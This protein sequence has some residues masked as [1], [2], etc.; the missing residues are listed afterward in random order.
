MIRTPASSIFEPKNPR[1]E[2]ECIVSGL[3]VSSFVRSITLLVMGVFIYLAGRYTGLFS[4]GVFVSSVVYISLTWSWQ[5]AVEGGVF[6]KLLL[7]DGT[8]TENAVFEMSLWQKI[9]RSKLFSTENRWQRMVSEPM[10]VEYFVSPDTRHDLDMYDDPM[11]RAVPTSK[12][13][14]DA[15]IFEVSNYVDMRRRGFS[16]F[17]ASF[18]KQTKRF[19][20]DFLENEFGS[21]LDKAPS[22]ECVENG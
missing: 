22:L 9:C 19:V 7:L 13:K 8:D 15:A 18:D 3:F 10:P 4:L 20:G 5:Y 1:I 21:E 11:R 12:E 14:F 16:K 2:T 6:K 17:Q